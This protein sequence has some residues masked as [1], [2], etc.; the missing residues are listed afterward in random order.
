MLGREAF[1]AE[2]ATAVVADLA[3]AAA[4]GTATA[5]ALAQRGGAGPHRSDE[6]TR[7]E[8]QVLDLLA[9]GRSNKEIAQTLILSVRTV[10]NHLAHVYAKLGVSGRLEAVVAA[11]RDR[12]ADQ[13][14]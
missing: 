11:Q 13:A 2:W 9:A 10:E 12:R 1:D 14:S 4:V 8:A 6:L 7:R 5:T 3:A